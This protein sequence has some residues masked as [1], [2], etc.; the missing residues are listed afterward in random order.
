MLSAMPV[1]RLILL[2]IV[3]WW[4]GA[5]V[6][7]AGSE[8]NAA[9]VYRQALEKLP[10]SEDDL[11]LYEQWSAGVPVHQM[12]AELMGRCAPAFGLLHDATAIRPSNW[13]WD[14]GKGLALEPPEIEESK[15]MAQAAA[16]QMRSLLEQKRRDEAAAL[17]RDVLVMGRRI[18]AQPMLAA[19]DADE[20]IEHA[21]F[22]VAARYLPG[23][24]R[25]KLDRLTVI[26]TELPALPH[27][28]ETLEG[29][30]RLVMTS[31]QAP[32]QSAA[33]A[34]LRGPRSPQDPKDERELARQV[35]ELFRSVVKLAARPPEETGP[36]LDA[37]GA[38]Y[39]QAAP[40]VR[41][42]VPDPRQAAS[43]EARRKAE[44]ALFL[45]AITV[46]RNG[47]GALKTTKDPYSDG[48]FGY[49]VLVDGF[50]LRSKL[51][52]NGA[53][54]ILKCGPQAFE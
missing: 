43:Q 32:P 5:P 37:F 25:D 28:K 35:E 21:A 14:F 51:A 15:Q 46:V 16:I 53:P 7:R 9:D 42:L 23:T 19:R 13:G 38:R 20:Q 41:R 30:Q 27:L 10:K 22:V 26:V 8:D 24:P 6:A 12:A 50:Q 36:A 29:Q 11:H 49:D 39:S 44:Q 34:P 45:A 40:I 31:L 33:R 4:I 3:V 54:V 47:R 48:P 1:V 2:L 52:V 18:G 17:F